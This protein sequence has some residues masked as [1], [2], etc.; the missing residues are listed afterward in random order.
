VDTGSPGIRSRRILSAGFAVIALSFL[1]LFVP[2]IIYAFVLAFQARGVPDQTAINRFAAAI[3]P[4]L[5]PWLERFLT[6]FL[7]FRLV[8]RSDVARAADGL[9]VGIVAGLLG[10]AVVLAFG[11]RLSVSSLLPVVV[12]VGLGWLG[13]FAGQRMPSKP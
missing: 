8:R 10:L 11:G 1:V 5:M 9:F 13:G 3:S 7:A 12:V 4:V 2:I 6:L